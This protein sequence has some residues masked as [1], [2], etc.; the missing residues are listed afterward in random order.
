MINY[1]KYKIYY[2]FKNNLYKNQIFLISF[3]I[4]Y[5]LLKLA[6]KLKYR[7]VEIKKFIIKINK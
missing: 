6:N 7:I 2:N 4:K 1:M 5:I 3:Y